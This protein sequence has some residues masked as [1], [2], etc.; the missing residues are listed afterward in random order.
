MECQ[1]ITNEGKQ[2]SRKV[3]FN[4]KYCWQ[5]QNYEVNK[6]FENLPLLQN[7]L[8]PYF[9]EEEPLKN[10]NKQFQNLNYEKYNTPQIIETYHPESEI[11]WY[12]ETLKNGKQNGLFEQW[13]KN[14]VP[15]YK[16]NIKNDEYDGL[17]EQWYE[18]GLLHLRDNYIDGKKDGIWEEYYPNGKLYEK[19]N[20][21]DGE[22]NG[23]YENY[24]PNG[25]LRR[26]FNYK[27]GKL[28]GSL[29]NLHSNG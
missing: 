1:A 14:G 18:D 11:L 26:R 12:R 8:L 24:Y 13:Y 6:Y 5:H 23:L 17:Y 9:S 16:Y 4:S 19:S 29:E 7:T 25:K 27:N 2:C 21:K 15:K 20:Y 22:L 28:D 3:E 10:L